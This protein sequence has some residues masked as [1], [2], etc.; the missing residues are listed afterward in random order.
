M[1]LKLLIASVAIVATATAATAATHKHHHR[2]VASAG[3][4]AAPSQPVAYA[5]LDAYL[6][7]PQS[8]RA[9]GDWGLDTATAA[10]A[11]TGAGANV[12]A[13]APDTSG[14]SGQPA[15]AMPSTESAPATQAAPDTQS[16]P[17]ADQSGTSPP[18]NSGSGNQQ[19][20][21]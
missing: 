16:A 9:S 4:Y 20:P 2:A 1:T 14:Q 7:A 11:Q 17:G 8:Q 15:A 19:N 10:S 3:R 6:K 5:K 13:T 18:A 21:M 12:S